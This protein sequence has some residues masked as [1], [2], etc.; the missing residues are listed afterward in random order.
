MKKTVLACAVVMAAIFTSAAQA[1][2]M[3]EAE[4]RKALSG[5]IRGGD[6]AQVQAAPI[7]GIFEVI[8]EGQLYYVT[9]DGRYLFQGKAF[10]LL[11]GKD[12]TEPRMNDVRAQQLNAVDDKQTVI[13]K[14]KGETK[15]RVDV[16]TDIDCHY[17]RELHKEMAGYLERG[18][19]IRYLFF[20]RAGANSPSARKA[21]AVWCADDRQQAMTDA[22][23]FRKVESRRCENPVAAHY[24]LGKD[25][26]VRAT[27]TIMTGNGQVIPGFRPPETLEQILQ[28]L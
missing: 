23:A 21:E 12:L 20:P 17:C 28:Q 4:V 3:G 1:A 11:E 18:I 7:P 10:D 6:T 19:E 5:K 16:F 9:A 24:Q 14:P 27:P 22:K 26:G 2:E 15:Y 8:A 25:V 13:F